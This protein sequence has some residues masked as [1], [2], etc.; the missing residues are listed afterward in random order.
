MALLDRPRKLGYFVQ[1][2]TIAIVSYIFSETLQMSE[3]TLSKLHT[4]LIKIPPFTTAERQRSE[5]SRCQMPEEKM[6]NT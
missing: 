4:F 3:R 6:H 2:L 5:I 1:K